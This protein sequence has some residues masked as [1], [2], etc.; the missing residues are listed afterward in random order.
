MRI[1]ICDDN[2]QHVRQYTEKLSAIG[3]KHGL[4]ST[5][6]QYANGEQLLFAQEDAAT[7]ADIIF[8][9]IRMPGRDGVDIAHAL[10][11]MQ[12]DGEIIFFT[13]STENMLD[14][15]DVDALHYIVKGQTSDEKIEE[16]FLRAI[17]RAEQKQQETIVLAY[18][19]L[20][21]NVPITVCSVP[22]LVSI[23]V[24][25]PPAQ[26]NYV[27]GTQFDPAGMVVTG[28]YNDGSSAPLP[29]TLQGDLTITA[30]RHTIVI[31]AGGLTTEFAAGVL[32]PTSGPVPTA[33]P[34]PVLP[35]VSAPPAP[36]PIPTPT[37]TPTPTPSPSP[38]PSPTAVPPSTPP[39]TPPAQV[40]QPLQAPSAAQGLLQ[41]KPHEVLVGLSVGSVVGFSA[42]LAPDVYV[43]LWYQNKKNQ[44][45][46]RS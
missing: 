28:Y 13:H 30:Q 20:S 25:T 23:A 22:V 11:E 27:S 2:P 39:S 32:Q 10:R 17:H 3:Q 24:T 37:L 42:L 36:T 19:S 4:T 15:F 35:A 34:V 31:E 44:Y 5:I 45:R 6:D 41:V 18:G 12:Q 1:A 33:A 43:L 26:L 40:G 7:H 21:I 16:I 46:R 8:L 38:Q 9:D 14:A 29:Y